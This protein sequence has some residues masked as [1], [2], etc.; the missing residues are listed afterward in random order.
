MLNNDVK[1]LEVVA[2]PRYWEDATVNGVEDTKGILVPLRNGAFW[3][4]IIR[5]EDGFIENW[6][7]GVF[8]SIH[9]KVC[10]QGE[11]WLLDEES[12]RRYKYKSDYVP[13]SLLCRDGSGFGDY[14]IMEINGDGFIKGWAPP[15]LKAEEWSL[16]E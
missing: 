14:I 16:I 5:L 8:A 1:Y 2:E 12:H 10:D 4:P 11:Y 9:Y 3:C 15:I 6:E 13:D 7:A